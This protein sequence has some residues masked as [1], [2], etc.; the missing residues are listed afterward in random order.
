MFGH[1]S[2]LPRLSVGAALTITTSSLLYG[3]NQNKISLAEGEKS[4][5]RIVIVGGGTGGIGVAGMLKNDGY[6]D[7]TLIEPKD[8]HFYQPLW[9]LVGGGIKPVEESS[10]PMSKILA[11]NTKWI[12]SSVS[13]FDPDN[14]TVVLSNGT[15]VPYDYLVV[16]V[17]IIASFD[18]IP[19]AV[20]ALNDPNSGVVSVYDYNYAAKTA[21]VVG[22]IKE[23]ERAIFTAPSTPV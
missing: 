16:A 11:S 13:T 19:G 5:P 10:R 9:T 12:Q 21:K 7:V 3:N 17:G 6:K 4:T 23:G 8:H 22:A 20:E 1:L 18:Q 15:K 14:N 2:R